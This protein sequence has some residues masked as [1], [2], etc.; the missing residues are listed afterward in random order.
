MIL[1]M[2]ERIKHRLVGVLVIIAMAAIF[3]PAMVKTSQ[4]HFEDNLKLSVK[5]PAKP[6]LP[7]VVILDKKNLLKS[8]KVA[9]VT[10]PKTVIPARTI[11]LAKAQP[12]MPVMPVSIVPSAPKL[13]NHTVVAKKKSDIMRNNVSKGVPVTKTNIVIEGVKKPL[14]AVQLAS[15]SQQ[16]NAQNLVDLL[17]SK[18]YVASYNKAS[19][20]EGALFYTVLVGQLGQRDQALHLQQQLV[21]SL[22]LNGFIVKTENS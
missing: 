10:L 20:R 8:V 18:G 7:K 1:T 17:R 22:K 5:L 12:I 16:S 2:D 6:P 9:Q 11:A 19:G 14:Y 21:S 4:H 3:V 13:T 15:F